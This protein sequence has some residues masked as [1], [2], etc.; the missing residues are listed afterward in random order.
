MKET[1]K[2]IN[3]LKEEGLLEDY[4]IGGAI[5]VLKWVEPFFTRDL[6]VFIILL[7]ETKDKKLIS[8]SPIHEYLKN[9]GYTEWV[10]QWLMIE[11]VP[12]EFIPV[13]GLS[14]EAVKNAIET[15]F[16]GVKIKVIG[17]EYLIALLLVAGRQKDIVKIEMLL[18]EAKVDRN[19]LQEIL[20]RHSLEEKLKPFLKKGKN[21]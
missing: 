4:A 13:I 18:R 19:K 21:G 15:E 14:K 10:G 3:R 2:V 20:N 12:V 7:P 9:K 6:D 11:G 1:L 8:L 5:A 16:E 17:P